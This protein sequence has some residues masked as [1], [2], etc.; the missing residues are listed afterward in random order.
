[1]EKTSSAP[2]DAHADGCGTH[3]VSFMGSLYTPHETTPVARTHYGVRQRPCE[4]IPPSSI[5]ESPVPPYWLRS[6]VVT[7]RAWPLDPTFCIPV[8]QYEYDR[9]ARSEIDRSKAWRQIDDGERPGDA[10]TPKR[11]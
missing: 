2:A 3:R 5:A 10:V 8:M 7:V 6:A 4:L 1:M 11:A 9:H